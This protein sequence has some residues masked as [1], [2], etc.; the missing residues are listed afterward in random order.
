MPAGGEWTTATRDEA[1]L[2]LDLSSSEDLE[3]LA[4]ALLDGT[5][6]TARQSS[7]ADRSAEDQQAIDR[8]ELARQ[9]AAYWEH[10]KGVNRRSRGVV[11][12]DDVASESVLA[13]YE[14]EANGH[15]IRSD[16]AYLRTFAWGLAQQ[17][18]NHG[19]NPVNRKALG[20]FR[21]LCAEK[22]VGLGRNLTRV[23]EDEIA[24]DLRANWHDQKRRP[25]EYFRTLEGQM[26]V[27]VD[28]GENAD[29]MGYLLPNSVH[30]IPGHDD[31]EVRPG[32]YTERAILAADGHDGDLRDAKMMAWAV[33][34]E[35]AVESSERFYDR[36]IP[37]VEAATISQRRV[38][39]IRETIKEAGGVAAVAE[40]WRDGV[41]DSTTEAL[42]EP[43]GE[44]TMQQRED[45]VDLIT[46]KPGR[47]D[48][49]WSS[50]CQ[51]ANNRNAERVR[52]LSTHV[53]K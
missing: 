15:S 3:A 2:T 8:L 23:E 12:E 52:A 1:D 18:G 27:S 11:D 21:A 16:K 24:G 46:Y 45:I 25:S 31:H 38:T 9:S 14:R 43:W 5:Y 29:S 34:V 50:A 44:T 32:T 13:L 53:S 19:V 40:T 49:L 22:S 47:A 33:A 4:D 20:M 7:F 48:Q 26:E 28:A 10:N 35:E 17:G 41:D 36:D 37:M 42:F 39:A 30:G 6:E 51:M